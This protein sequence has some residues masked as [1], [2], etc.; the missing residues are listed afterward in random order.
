MY[1]MGSV[2]IF[3]CKFLIIEV[4]QGLRNHDVVN[5]VPRLSKPTDHVLVESFNG[6]FR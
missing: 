4:D 2:L 5:T 6:S 1:L 3:N